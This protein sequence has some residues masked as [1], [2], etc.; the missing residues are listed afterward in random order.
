MCGRRPVWSRTCSS[1]AASALG[2][3]EL[4]HGEH[5]VAAV[6]HLAVH[7]EL[8]LEVGR[9]GDGDLDE[10][11]V[12]GVGGR[13]LSR[14]ICRSFSRYSAASRLSGSLATSRML[15]RAQSRMN[16]SAGRVERDVGDAQLEGAQEPGERARPAGCRR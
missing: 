16:S 11:D 13:S 12:V 8:G 4:L 7:V 3:V 14:L 15:R 10:D 2:T 9:V 6:P 5:P 1:S